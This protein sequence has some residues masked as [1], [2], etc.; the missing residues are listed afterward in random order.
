MTLFARNQKSFLTLCRV[1]F[2]FAL[3][4][5]LMV[6]SGSPAQANPPQ[7][8]V[9]GNALVTASGGCTVRLTG[10]NVDST[11][12]MAAGDF[13]SG[14]SFMT[15]VQEA[16][17]YW[18]VNLIR[19]AI[20]QDW[21]DGFAQSSRRA[22]PSQANYQALVDSVVAYCNTNNIYC[23]LDLHWSGTGTTGTAIQQY[24]MPDDNSATFW[25]SV[26]ARYANNPSVLFDPFQ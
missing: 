1:V 23:D 10:V 17:Q 25:A 14:G 12:W 2:S 6:F 13:P 22:P 16:V 9:Q 11:E 4:L 21:W 20:D 26:A 5:V 18:N 19:V 8:K 24:S 15:Q 3:I 7:L